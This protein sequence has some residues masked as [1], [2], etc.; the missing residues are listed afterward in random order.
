MASEISS[1]TVSRMPEELV[2]LKGAVET[3]PVNSADADCAAWFQH[4]EYCDN[5]SLRNRL[6]MQRAS[7]LIFISL[8]GPSLE[9]FNALP[10]VKK[11][12]SV[13]SSRSVR[14][15]IQK[16]PATARIPQSHAQ[17]FRVI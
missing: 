15:S 7:N 6:D 5:S 3:I 13:T 14:N 17:N 11:W 4:D 9:D 1:T 10:Y 8:V 12:F 16:M 2:E